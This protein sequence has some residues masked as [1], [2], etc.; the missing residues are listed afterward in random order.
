MRTIVLIFV[1]L[2]SVATARAAQP[3]SATEWNNQAAVLEDAGEFAAAV[4]AYEY[5]LSLDQANEAIDRNLRRA[6]LRAMIDRAHVPA[7]WVASL[8]GT[9]WGGRRM[10][11]MIAWLRRRRRERMLYR[12]I[13]VAGYAQSVVNAFGQ[14]EP[15]GRV[16]PN[17][18]SLHVTARLSIHGP[19]EYPLCV[20]LNLASPQGLVVTSRQFMGESAGQQVSLE[21]EVSDLAAVMTAGGTWGIELVL[22]NNNAVLCRRTVEHVSR[23]MLV[24]DLAVDEPRLLVLDG[25]LA[26]ASAFALT[27]AESIIPSLRVRP[28][29]YAAEHLVGSSLRMELVW[30]ATG[31]VIRTQDIPLPLSSDA[32]RLA[33]LAQP[34]RGDVLSNYPGQ[35]A[36]RLS[37]DGRVLTTLEMLVVTPQ[38]VR[39]AVRVEQFDVLGCDASGGLAPVGESVAAGEYRSLMPVAR[40]S[41]PLPLSAALHEVIIGVVINEQVVGH[42]QDCV[43]LSDRSNIVTGGELP[44][45]GVTQ[46]GPFS[47]FLFVNGQCAAERTVTLQFPSRVADVQGRL[48]SAAAHGVAEI[49]RAA[50]ELLTAARVSA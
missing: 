39:D 20:A 5:A 21:F 7:A 31:A 3:R 15:D 16:Y 23:A 27:T 50:A 42:V 44:L 49:E 22:Q 6:R 48:T 8:L 32:I 9:A 13:R 18:Q 46:A 43:A 29:A 1:V 26:Q 41:T 4:T 10:L 36:M 19:V 40:L 30:S 37:V 24:G 38:Q 17:A 34:V 47:F 45:G 25:G 33:E 2:G 14:I 35:W 28:A 11:A 12:G